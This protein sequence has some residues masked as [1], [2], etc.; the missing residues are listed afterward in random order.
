VRAGGCRWQ[1]TDLRERRARQARDFFVRRR[2]MADE[3]DKEMQYHLQALIL[4]VASAALIGLRLTYVFGEWG[5][6]VVMIV[7]GTLDWP[8]FTYGL[9]CRS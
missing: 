3:E 5:S 9:R 7:I 6:C 1:V 4:S 2:K 8:R